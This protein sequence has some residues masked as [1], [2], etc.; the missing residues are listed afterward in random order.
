MRGLICLEKKVNSDERDIME[1]IEQLDD[2]D[3][4][5]ADAWLV[6]A[7]GRLLAFLLR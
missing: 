4:Y 2:E 7:E 3:T 5:W 1:A 6:K